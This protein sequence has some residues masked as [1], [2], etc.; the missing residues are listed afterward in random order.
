M[1]K[2]SRVPQKS[3]LGEDIRYTAADWTGLIRSLDDGALEL[4]TNRPDEENRTRAARGR[5]RELGDLLVPLV[6]TARSQ[7]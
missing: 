3:Q 2:I 5:S 4:N 1:N 7:A 6:D